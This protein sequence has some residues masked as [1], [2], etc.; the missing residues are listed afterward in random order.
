[1]LTLYRRHKLPVLTSRKD[2][3]IITASAESGLTEYLAAEKFGSLSAHATG[4]KPTA[5]FRGGRPQSA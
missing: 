3:A 2:V 5:R 4:R 1:M